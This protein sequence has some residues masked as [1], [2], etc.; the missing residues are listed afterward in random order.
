MREAP[1]CERGGAEGARDV[2]CHAHHPDGKPPWE[3][4]PASGGDAAAGQWGDLAR[5]GADE[6]SADAAGG[7]D[8]ARSEGRAGADEGREQLLSRALREAE[9]L[10][11]RA[12]AAD[13]QRRQCLEESRG[14]QGSIRIVGRVRP[15]LPGE[16]QDA[17]CLRV[18]GRRQLEV[19]AEPRP[20]L[21]DQPPLAARRRAPEGPPGGRSANCTLLSDS[22]HSASAACLEARAFAFDD[23]FGADVGDEDVFAALRNELAAAVEGEA[24]CVLAYGATG[25]GKTHTVG[26]LAERAAEDLE[27]QALAMA[28]GG[29][30]LEVQV[31][32]VEIYNEQ[33]RDL[34]CPA[35][36]R[37]GESRR[38][39]LSCTEGSPALVGA[40]CHSICADSPGGV[41]RGIQKAY[42]VGQALRATGAT[43]VHGRSSRSH[44]V[45]VLSLAVWARDADG[46]P[47]MRSCGRLSLVDLAGSERLKKSEAEGQR[48]TEAQHINRSLSALADVI[49]AKERRLCHVP[50]RN[51]MLTRLLQDALGGQPRFRTVVIV[52]MTPARDDLGETLHSLQFSTRLSALSIPTAAA[53]RKSLRGPDLGPRS[54]P[55]IPDAD[56][57]HGEL[58]AELARWRRECA[59]AEAELEACRGQLEARESELRDAELERARLLASAE[60]FDRSRSWL[61]LGLAALDSKLQE[62]EKVAMRE[63]SVPRSSSCGSQCPS[64]AA[65]QRPPA[66]GGCSPCCSTQPSSP[67]RS[68]SG[69]GPALEPA[70]C[71]APGP[72]LGQPAPGALASASGVPSPRGS[73][74]AASG[75]TLPGDCAAG[76][77]GTARGRKDPHAEPAAWPAPTPSAFEASPG[78]RRA[79]EV[80]ALT[81]GAA[82]GPG[83]SPVAASGSQGGSAT[84]S[85]WGA[86]APS[87]RSLSPPVAAA[88]RGCTS[89]AAQAVSSRRRYVVEVISEAQARALATTA[90]LGR[91]SASSCGGGSGCEEPA[92]AQVDAGSGRA[93]LLGEIGRGPEDD[94]VSVSSDEEEIRNRLR[95]SLN[96]GPGPRPRGAPAAGGGAGAAAGRAPARVVAR[97]PPASAAGRSASA[98]GHG[99]VAQQG[100]AP[101]RGCAPSR[102]RSPGVGP[103]YSAASAADP[104]AAAAFPA[105]QMAR[106]GPP[107]HHLYAPV[108]SCRPSGTRTWR[109]G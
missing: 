25:S 88:R 81:P 45:M 60:D 40:T 15:V 83:L 63:P 68:C 33:L 90:P 66:L 14:L 94:A 91:R 22:C 34:L 97:P 79:A 16:G 62:V 42:R 17:Q 2:R 98:R 100:A 1:R 26:S 53:S 102:S 87:A 41:A 67:R 9:T 61:T 30:R 32:M 93:L 38:L 84:A 31:Q 23:V 86:S 6:G 8:E 18:L 56:E 70:A 64:W 65:E 57:A 95:R 4:A 92:Q 3:Q 106:G 37:G 80:F 69:G 44:L 74:G 76:G 78:A 58:E 48:L 77:A 43:A 36:G 47:R 72:A 5:R 103:Q 21:A 46:L 7:A 108:L 54:L 10:Q 101:R 99:A 20:A 104:R 105:A 55:C 51:S 24:V 50:Y 49:S 89:A 27:R 109:R 107:P 75:G 73:A 52:A 19:L 59:R 35:G 13:A 29:T 11:G 85:P 71:A 12:A 39:R 82:E 96:L 28:E